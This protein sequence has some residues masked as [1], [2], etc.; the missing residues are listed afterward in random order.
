MEIFGTNSIHQKQMA[1]IFI[2]F[3]KIE[4]LDR[5]FLENTVYFST[6]FA[7]SLQ[8]ILFGWNHAHRYAVKKLNKGL[9]FFSFFLMLLSIV[10]N[11][12]K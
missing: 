10:Y 7:F 2:I 5:Q 12:L 4:M 1:A 9:P 11:V 6:F 8:V 3:T